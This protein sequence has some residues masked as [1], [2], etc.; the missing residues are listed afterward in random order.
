ME[1]ANTAVDMVE[2]KKT[3]QVFSKLDTP[4]RDWV[5]G[6][7]VPGTISDSGTSVQTVPAEMHQNIR[8]ITPTMRSPVAGEGWSPIS[9]PDRASV[10]GTLKT[11]LGQRLRIGGG[12][13]VPL[14]GIP[15][16]I[17]GIPMEQSG[18][19]ETYMRGVS[20]AYLLEEIWEQSTEEQEYEEE[21]TV[22][23]LPVVQEGKD[24]EDED[25]SAKESTGGSP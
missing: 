10:T 14:L 4:V 3:A 18:L 5:L 23:T 17:G 20:P 25:T 12:P 7:A 16:D 8:P 2:A 9:T 22:P 15:I 19:L 6:Q 24:S 13:A 11:T 21:S 1:L